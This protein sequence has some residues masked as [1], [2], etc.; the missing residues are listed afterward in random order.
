MNTVKIIS[1]CLPTIFFP[2]TI[3][4]TFYIKICRW[5]IQVL[6]NIPITHTSVKLF[7]LATIRGLVK[8][9]EEHSNSLQLKLAMYSACI[10]WKSVVCVAFFPSGF[11]LGQIGNAGML[12]TLLA[13]LD[14]TH[15]TPSPAKY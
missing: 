1:T 4:L 13:P 5:D 15:H 14:L 8:Q 12:Q 11:S 6:L 7:M 3:K 10:V 2:L 9:T